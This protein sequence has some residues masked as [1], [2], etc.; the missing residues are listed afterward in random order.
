MQPGFDRYVRFGHRLV[1]GWVDYPILW[2]VRNL[3]LEQERLL[4]TGGMAEIGVHHGR[5]FLALHLARR[6]GERSAAIDLFGDQHLNQDLSG[7]G[8]YKFFERNL[9]LH[10]GGTEDVEILTADSSALVGS[11]VTKIVGGKVRLFSVDGGH[12]AELVEHDMMTAADSLATGG[13]V[14]ADDVFNAAWPGVAEGTFRFLS[15]RPDL[16]PFAVGFNKV[17]F[18]APD[19]ADGYR[20]VVARAAAARA[21]LHA[22]ESRMAGHAVIVCTHFTARMRLRQYAG[23]ALRRLGVLD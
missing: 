23:K 19:F 17:L 21:R 10:A 14:I 16:V 22:H 18:A 4:V 8:N 5:F 15:A 11:D 2:L 13:I 20:A 3:A 9:R 12:T 1:D 6:D 7:R